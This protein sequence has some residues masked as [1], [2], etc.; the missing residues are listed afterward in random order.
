MKDARSSPSGE[1]TFAGSV[2]DRMAPKRNTADAVYMIHAVPA[3]ALRP[4]ATGAASIVPI[5]PNRVIRELTLTS[6]MERGWRRGTTALRV[7]P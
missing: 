3:V 4:P 7:T 2:N 1:S 6:D 5:R